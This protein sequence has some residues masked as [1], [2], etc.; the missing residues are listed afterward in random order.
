MLEGIVCGDMTTRTAELDDY[1]RL[2]DLQDYVDSQDEGT[3]LKFPHSQEK[4]L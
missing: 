4:Q 3:Y 1:T 2:A